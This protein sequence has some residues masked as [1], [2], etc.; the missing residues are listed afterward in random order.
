MT[1]FSKRSKVALLRR[2]LRRKA[3]ALAVSLPLSLGSPLAF[4]LGLGNAQVHSALG[5]PLLAE[6]PLLRNNERYN[7]DEI[8]VTQVRGSRALDLGYD[9]AADAEPFHLQLVDDG[10][11]LVLRVRSRK[12]LNE[13]FVSLLVELEWPTGRLI[14]DYDLLLDL[15][16]ASVTPAQSSAP[17]NPRAVTAPEPPQPQASA[18][19]EI[20][21]AS[22]VG[23]V[24]NRR[25]SVD[26]DSNRGGSNRWRVGRGDTLWEIAREI[27]PDDRIKLTDVVDALYRLNPQAFENGDI[28]RLRGGSLLKLPSPED[29]GAMDYRGQGPS[30]STAPVAAVTPMQMD[31]RYRVKAGDTLSQIAQKYRGTPA[32]PLDIVM[33][34]LYQSNPTAFSRGDMDRLKMGVLLKVPGAGA[35]DT[36]DRKTAQTPQSD[37]PRQTETTADPVVTQ[38]DSQG[39]IRLSKGVDPSLPL[40]SSE[41]ILQQIDMVAELVDKVNRENQS[42]RARIEKIE[43]SEQLVLLERLLEL[44]SRQIENLKVAMLTNHG[45]VLSDAASETPTP[46]EPTVVSPTAATLAPAAGTELAVE[47]QTATAI[48][49]PASSASQPS[50]VEVVTVEQSPTPYSWWLPALLVLIAGVLGWFIRPL[51]GGSKRD[52]VELATSGAAT[53]KVEVEERHSD[54]NASEIAASHDPSVTPARAEPVDPPSVE[55]TADLDR[56]AANHEDPIEAQEDEAEIAESL[57]L[58]FSE[59]IQSA[60]PKD[61]SFYPQFEELEEESESGDLGFPDLQIREEDLDPELSGVPDEKREKAFD[62]LA[63]GALEEDFDF[64]LPEDFLDELDAGAASESGP[65]AEIWRSIESD[66]RDHQSAVEEDLDSWLSSGVKTPS[67]SEFDEL[68]NEAMIYAAYGRHEHAEALINEQLTQHPD[69]AKLKQALKEIRESGKQFKAGGV[70]SSDAQPSTNSSNAPDD[71]DLPK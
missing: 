39:Q 19:A 29:F 62:E 52:N 35:G 27:R 9:L 11:Q 71:L 13:P 46:A 31:G 1:T 40:N 64:S 53:T 18:A 50:A 38:A 5:Q 55:R 26:D 54:S 60:K 25:N 48:A 30:R 68:I 7:P 42:I 17:S 4:S 59:E 45:T 63:E 51:L 44:Q 6:I 12:V 57:D 23:T 33:Q 47:S 20:P 28:D 24:V 56:P 58:S 21:P 8:I 15:A 66:T 61:D 16:P 10:G 22:S 41:A 34:A 36:G 70:F 2:D 3:A 49:A 67:V 37:S 14:R 32:K 65:D 69:D 43:K